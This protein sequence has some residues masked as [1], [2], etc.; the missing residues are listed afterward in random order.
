[1]RHLVDDQP[2]SASVDHVAQPKS[3]LGVR[4]PRT[5]PPSM[6]FKLQHAAPR[7]GDAPMFAPNL[8]SHSRSPFLVRRWPSGNPGARAFCLRVRPPPE[9]LKLDKVWLG[10]LLTSRA[11]ID[12]AIWHLA[13]RLYGKLL[14]RARRRKQAPVH[15]SWLFHH[16][17]A[18][19]D[20]KGS[21]TAQG[22]RL[23]FA[24]PTGWF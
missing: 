24:R 8:E 16:G 7:S 10:E 13:W 19:L 6:R 11:G 20:L 21:R 3:S 2:P 18:Y 9:Q 15:T 5:T 22:H 4:R 23:L 17:L 12:C 1:M 14:Q